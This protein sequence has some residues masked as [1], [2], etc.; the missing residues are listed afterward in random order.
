MMSKN[1]QN[2][3]AQQKNGRNSVIFCPIS[4]NL[5]FKVIYSSRPIDWRN[6]NDC[7][8]FRLEFRIFGSKKGVAD[9]KWPANVHFWMKFNFFFAICIDNLFRTKMNYDLSSIEKN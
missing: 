9:E 1:G 7:I 6:E 3:A 5:V 8:S 2:L 4:I